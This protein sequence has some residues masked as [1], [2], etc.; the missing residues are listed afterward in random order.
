VTSSPD[1]ASPRSTHQLE[2]SDLSFSYAG[3]RIL[4]AVSMAVR[5]GEIVGLI[6][7]N[8]SGKTTL[9]RCLLGYLAP[10][11]G[12][13]LLD[14]RDV[15]RYPRRAFARLVASVAQ[16]TPTDIP[17]LASELVLLGRVPHL[18]MRGLGFEPVDALE[19]VSLALEQCGVLALADRPLHQLSGG[20]LR[21]VYL[22]RALVQEAPILLLDEPIAGLDLRHQ[23]AIL[24][25][26]ERQAHAGT[27]VLTV[28]HDVNLAASV[29]DRIVLLKAGA[30]VQAGTPEDVLTAESLAMLYEVDIRQIAL[31]PSDAAG[32]RR[33]FFV[34]S[35]RAREIDPDPWDWPSPAP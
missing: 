31:E 28:L 27:A 11:S 20:E 34:P 32:G 1:A 16:E 21:R 4:D 33:P 19:R 22:A 12:R 10:A 14:G 23:L 9:L 8:G 29:C 17:L 3:Q 26:L 25:I 30:V 13:A 24:H 7:P 5:S 18:P 15:S 2:A 35:L 6:G